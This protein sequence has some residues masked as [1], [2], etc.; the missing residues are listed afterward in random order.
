MYFLNYIFMCV[1]IG[2]YLYFQVNDAVMPEALRQVNVWVSW[3]FILVA[4]YFSGRVIVDCLMLSTKGEMSPENVRS[5]ILLAVLQF[6][7]TILM[8]VFML[9][10]GFAGR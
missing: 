5:G 4:L 3:G 7:P 10:E 8:S 9:K 2:I 6:L 1:Y